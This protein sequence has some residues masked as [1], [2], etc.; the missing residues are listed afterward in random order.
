MIARI[1]LGFVATLCAI[2]LV[3]FLVFMTSII[4]ESEKPI[5]CTKIEEATVYLQSLKDTLLED[6]T[7]EYFE[8]DSWTVFVDAFW[9]GFEEQHQ[10]CKIC[11]VQP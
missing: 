1:L 10:Y 11:S 4:E 9:D 3:L 2:I 8:S 5:Q 7:E 6:Y